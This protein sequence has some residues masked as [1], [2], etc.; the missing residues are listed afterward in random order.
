MVGFYGVI[1]IY[2]TILTM[3]CLSFSLLI[4]KG[5]NSALR[6]EKEIFSQRNIQVINL[7]V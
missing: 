2:I 1:S 3:K 4:I 7:V 5:N 6:L